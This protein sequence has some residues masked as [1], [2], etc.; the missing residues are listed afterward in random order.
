MNRGRSFYRSVVL[1]AI[2][3]I[4]QNLIT[5]SLG[6]LDTFMVGRLGEAPMAAVTLA[7][8]PIFVVQ[9]MTFGLQSGASV[10]ISQFHGKGDKGSIN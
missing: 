5:N 8:I 7:N 3:I 10:L 4:L 1:L 6:L 2:P 9:L